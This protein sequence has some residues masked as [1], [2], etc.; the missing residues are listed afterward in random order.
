MNF[1]GRAPPYDFIFLIDCS[2]SKLIFVLLIFF[3][4]DITKSIFTK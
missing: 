2:A 1:S 4:N 3:I